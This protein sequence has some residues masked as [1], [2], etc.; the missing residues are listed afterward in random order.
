MPLL[1]SSLDQL[2]DL[3]GREAGLS[4][5]FT[6]QQP[7]IDAFA[8]LTRDEQWIHT[9]PARAAAESPFQS[10]VAHGFFT[11]SLLT[12]FAASAFDLQLGQSALINYGLNRVRF[13]APAP[14]G[15]RLRARFSLLSATPNPAR[16]LEIVWQ[17][18]VEA[19]GSPKP[20]CSAEWV[21][22]VLFHAAV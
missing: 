9:D 20:V 17:V 12:Q 6:I 1:I 21:T 22:L 4:D 8:S 14:A 3:T 7:D 19:A 5:W 11:L 2:R 13:P 15:A 10:T 18:T 16:G